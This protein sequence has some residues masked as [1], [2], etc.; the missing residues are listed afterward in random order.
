MLPM[1]L[2]TISVSLIK[3]EKM[4]VT[5]PGQRQ[6]EMTAEE[7]SLREH[8]IYLV[9]EFSSFFGELPHP[10]GRKRCKVLIGRGQM[11]WV[12]VLEDGDVTNRNG[13]CL[14]G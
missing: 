12:V 8:L 3:V 14:A 13:S 1:I 5:W 10:V 7:P 2:P 4:P 6:E 11:F 9:G